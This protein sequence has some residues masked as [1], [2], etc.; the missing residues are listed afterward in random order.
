MRSKNCII[1]ALLVV[2]LSS[3]MGQMAGNSS[4]SAGG[5]VVGQRAVAWN[6]PTPYGMVH[7]KRGSLKI[8]RAHV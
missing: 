2:I 4:V 5:E 1:V 8:G 7:I 6:E 3:C